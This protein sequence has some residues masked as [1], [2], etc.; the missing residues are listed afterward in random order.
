MGRAGCDKTLFPVSIIFIESKQVFPDDIALV[1]DS[2]FPD[3]KT[4]IKPH[5]RIQAAKII[6]TFYEN[7]F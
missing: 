4:A 6:S 5:D 2:P 7:N 1:K 3:Y